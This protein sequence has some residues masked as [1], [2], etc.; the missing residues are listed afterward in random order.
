VAVAGPG[1]T[2]AERHLLGGDRLAVKASAAE[3][4]LRLLTDRLRAA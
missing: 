3:A 4:A 2:T 1:G